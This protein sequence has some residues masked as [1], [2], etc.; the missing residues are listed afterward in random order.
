MM[1][2][3]WFMCFWILLVSNAYSDLDSLGKAGMSAFG[4]PCQTPGPQ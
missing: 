3:D 1:L 4:H 2:V